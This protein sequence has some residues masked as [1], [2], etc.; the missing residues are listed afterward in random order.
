M[1]SITTRFIRPLL[2]LGALAGSSVALADYTYTSIDYPGAAYTQVFGINNSGQ[3][4]GSGL[5]FDINGI[6]NILVATFTYNS[7]KGTFTPLAQPPGTSKADALG[8]NEPGVMVGG[9]TFD[10][11]LTES[12]F[13]RSKQGAYT[14][15]RHP[16]CADTTARAINNTGLVSGYADTCTASDFVGFIY[17]PAR[18]LY[19][20]FLPGPLTIAQ[21]INNR[22]QVVG[23]VFLD[24]GVACTGCLAGRYGFLRAANGAVSYFRVNGRST[25]ARGIT[26]S[27]LITGFVSVGS[28][29]NKG[30]VI[31]LAG[32]PYESINTTLLEFPGALSTIPEGISNAGAIVGIWNAA[33][34]PSRGFIAMP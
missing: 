9:V 13:V 19:T 6:P 25:A 14:V 31:T 1:Q 4:V 26:D 20:D 32:L 12:G 10:G 15:F 30:F 33:S 3:A 34:G 7:K 11:G 29:A 2:L 21:G 16:G 5:N 18:N 8:I 27:G 24:P 23:S 22:G 17:D 28:G